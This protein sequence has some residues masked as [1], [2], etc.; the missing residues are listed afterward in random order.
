MK[1][2]IVMKKLD[3]K[4]VEMQ[5]KLTFLNFGSSMRRICR[6]KIKLLNKRNGVK[7]QVIIE[8]LKKLCIGDKRESSGSIQGEMA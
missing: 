3:S 8:K 1:N 2:V 7:E 5:P 6:Y 4:S